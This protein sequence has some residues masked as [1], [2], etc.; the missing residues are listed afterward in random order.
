MRS[1]EL[2]EKELVRAKNAAYRYLSYRSRSQAEVEA[3]LRDNEFSEAV[4]QHV[5][6]HLVRLGY[7]DDEMFSDQ[8]ARGRVRLRGFGRLRIEQELRNKGVSRDIIR[9]TLGEVFEDSSEIDIARREAE[10]K[11]R[12]LS[13][14]EPEVRRRRLAAFLERKGFSSDIIRIVMHDVLHSL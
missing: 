11:T 2:E 12:S 5:L 14:F 3:K 13:R 7:L 1:P 8:W 6:S 10:K 4:I 9:K